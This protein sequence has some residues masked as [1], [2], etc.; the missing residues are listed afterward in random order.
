MRARTGILIL[1]LALIAPPVSYGRG[2]AHSRGFRS[3]GFGGGFGNGSGGF[4]EPSQVRNYRSAP[5]T[6]SSKSSSTKSSRSSSNLSDDAFSPTLAPNGSQVSRSGVTRTLG[7]SG[8]S[9]ASATPNA[10]TNQPT[11][12][13]TAGNQTTQT[14]AVQFVN[15]FPFPYGLGLTSSAD[16]ETNA[17]R[18]FGPLVSNARNLIR[19]GVYP[20]AAQLLQRVIAGAPGTRIAAEAQRMLASLP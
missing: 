4:N 17:R 5:A 16:P 2:G 15:G 10:V 11:A 12:A 8:S 19:A 13:A 20:P 14:P 6:S 18:Q 3:G 7:Q 9:N 1:T